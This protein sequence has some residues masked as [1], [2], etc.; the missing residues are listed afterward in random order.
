MWIFIIIMSWTE[1]DKLNLF[2][3]FRLP[4]MLWGKRVVSKNNTQ[5]ASVIDK[6]IF[7]YISPWHLFKTI[8]SDT[9]TPRTVG[10]IVWSR[11]SFF[12]DFVAINDERD[13]YT[14]HPDLW[15]ASSLTTSCSWLWSTVIKIQL[16]LS[17]FL[18][19][20]DWTNHLWQ[21]IYFLRFLHVHDILLND[22]GCIPNTFCLNYVLGVSYLIC[23]RNHC[24]PDGYH[25]FD[26]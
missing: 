2:N 21:I 15:A 24:E 9:S 3:Q 12:S 1:C 8:K 5:F 25:P 7:I 13:L 14:K 23:I 10:R 16:I 6:Q 18:F 26:R 4:K 17:A 11:E 19:C 22:Y 20:L